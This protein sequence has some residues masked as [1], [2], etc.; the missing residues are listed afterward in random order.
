MFL[1]E[2]FYR[3]RCFERAEIDMC[4]YRGPQWMQRG[5]CSAISFHSMPQSQDNMATSELF[6]RVGGHNFIIAPVTQN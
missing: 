5:S 6:P 3:S 1:K 2:I 4:T